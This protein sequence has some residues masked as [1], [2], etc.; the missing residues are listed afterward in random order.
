MGFH[1]D[2]KQTKNGYLIHGN[3]KTDPKMEVRK[4]IP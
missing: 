4:R 1:G 2:L 3:K